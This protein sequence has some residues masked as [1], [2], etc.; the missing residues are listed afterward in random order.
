[1]KLTKHNMYIIPCL[2]MKCNSFSKFF[3]G[4]IKIIMKLTKH[5]EK[6]FTTVHNDFLK[7]I[8]LGITARGLLITMLSLP[9]DW[10]FSIA[11]LASILKDGEH[12]IATALKELEKLGYLVRIRKC[13][14]GKVYDWEYIISDVRLP[15]NILEQ[16]FKNKKRHLIKNKSADNNASDSTNENS[17]SQSQEPHLKNQDVAFSYVKSSQN[18][19]ILINKYT[20]KYKSIYQSDDEYKT[21]KATEAADSIDEI[22]SYKQIVKDNIGYDVLYETEDT[23]QLDEM[24]DIITDT[25]CSNAETIRVGKEAK[26]ADAVKSMFMKLND[27]HIQYVLENLRNTTTK[28]KNIKAYI[29]TS[30]YNAVMTLNTHIQTQVNHAMYGDYTNASK[31]STSSYANI[32]PMF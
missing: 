5:L 13:K 27:S 4:R 15:D 14:A 19:Q 30:L 18:N 10:N 22:D 29:I 8:E 25:V 12:K 7:D 11:G 23:A 31:T 21:E 26:P 6:D 16:S 28:I 9:E 2:F 17:I 1:M 20:N 3:L 24:V 32:Q